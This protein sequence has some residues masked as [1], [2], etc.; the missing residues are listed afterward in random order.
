MSVLYRTHL[1]TQVEQDLMNALYNE[2]Q[3]T[4]KNIVVQVD[5]RISILIPNLRSTE[6]P[7]FT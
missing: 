7:P 5:H 6:H 2:L 3:N 4:I 1:E